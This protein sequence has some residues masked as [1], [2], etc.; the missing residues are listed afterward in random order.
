MKKVF[1]IISFLFITLLL[2]FSSGCKKHSTEPSDS[3]TSRV[4]ALKPNIYVYPTSTCSLSVKL[5]F[6]LGGNIIKSIPE[7]LTGWFVKVDPSGR[8]NDEYDYLFY[9]CI[10]PDMYQ[11]TSGWIV[12]RDSLLTFFSGNLLKTGFNCH[13]INDFIE[14]WIPRLVE[15]P[16]Y[17]IYPQYKFDID[18][19]IRLKLSIKPDNELRLFYAIKGTT[20]PNIDLKIPTIPQFSRD[21]FVVV[22]WGVVM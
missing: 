4:I 22:E 9:E 12:S 2:V 18:K 3:D 15:Y 19:I 5:E 17:I 14:Y 7:Y 13:E 16:Y 21:G 1:I 11:H 6:P 10:N 8:I 20:I